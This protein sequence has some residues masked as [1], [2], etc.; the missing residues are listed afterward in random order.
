MRKNP[1]YYPSEQYNDLTQDQKEMLHT[2]IY[3]VEEASGL[4]VYVYPPEVHVWRL[5]NFGAD[6]LFTSGTEGAFGPFK[7]VLYGYSVGEVADLNRSFLPLGMF[8]AAYS[9]SG[10]QGNFIQILEENFGRKSWVYG[11]TFASM[12]GEKIASATVLKRFIESLIRAKQR[13]SCCFDRIVLFIAQ[14]LLGKSSR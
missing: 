3:D 2:N 8:G 7:A 5:D 6:H 1:V 11:A 9:R 14:F 12:P 4:P 10:G 13:F